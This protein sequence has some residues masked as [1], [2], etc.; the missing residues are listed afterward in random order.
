MFN[1]KDMNLMTHMQ[2]HQ[3]DLNN[4]IETFRE[5]NANGLIDENHQLQDRLQKLELQ[6][7]KYDEMD[8]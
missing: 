6:S 4:L 2:E 3:K 7:K 8:Y 5:D 1:E